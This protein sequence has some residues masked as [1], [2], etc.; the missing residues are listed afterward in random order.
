MEGKT[1][2]KIKL[3]VCCILFLVIFIFSFAIGYF[4]VPTGT[5]VSILFSK[6]ITMTP[7]WSPKMEIVILKIRLPRILAATLIGAALSVSGAAY[8]GLFRNPLVSPDILGVSA[9]ASFGAALS[10]LLSRNIVMTQLS[11]FTFGMMAVSITYLIGFLF[12]KNG[13]PILVMILSG[14]IV[15]TLFNSFIS[16]IKLLADTNNVLPAIT[17]WMMGSLATISIS[18]I[19]I[20]AVPILVGMVGIFTLRWNLNVMAFGD[21]EARSLGV[22]TRML[23]FA[24]ICCATLMTAAAVSIGG[25]IALVGLIVPHM[26]RLLLG[27]NYRY[28]IPA[29]IVL[30]SMFLLAVD[31]ITRVLFVTEIPIGI[32]TSI[33]GAPIFLYLLFNTRKGWV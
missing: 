5:T 23:R 8:Q 25:V 1:T 28:L 6:L 31:D 20:A 12:S 17:F 29:S 10:L 15:G 32:V 30:G 27:A 9:G 19:T 26:A 21:E 11:A 16:I 4:Y 3:T 22:R 13:S 14:I 33:I 2:M 7:H 24:I 18:D